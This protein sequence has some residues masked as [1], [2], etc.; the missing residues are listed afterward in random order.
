[1][2][3]NT[4]TVVR[5]READAAEVAAIESAI[6]SQPWTEDGFKRSLSSPYT[7]YLVARQDEKI[8]GYAGLLRTFDE[9]DITNIAVRPEMQGNGIGEMLLR[10]LMEAGRQEGIVRFT[11]E[12]R[13][14]NEKAIRLYEKC[15][16]ASVGRRKNFYSFPTE[17]ANIMWTQDVRS[18]L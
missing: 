12:V 14:G 10:S 16:F 1:M 4:V 7:I 5:M 9:A 11:L 2:N 13:T 3:E 17:D 6:F 15:G 8:A 18:E